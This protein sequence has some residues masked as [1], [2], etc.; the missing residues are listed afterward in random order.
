MCSQLAAGLMAA[1]GKD[2][3]SF[4]DGQIIGIP[5]MVSILVSYLPVNI[6]AAFPPLLMPMI[7][8]GFV[9]GV[10]AVLILEHFVY[11]NNT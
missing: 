3:F 4:Q 5:M 8:N 9:M 10:L 7:G 2:G 11:R 1:F 6:K